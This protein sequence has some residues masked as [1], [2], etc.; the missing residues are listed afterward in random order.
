MQLA[1][2]FAS[3]G[4]VTKADEPT[5]CVP[6]FELSADGRKWTIAYPND[7]GRKWVD[8]L[9]VLAERSKGKGKTKTS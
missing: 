3:D 6:E 2:L 1:R 8:G 9:C 5:E 4:T 7:G